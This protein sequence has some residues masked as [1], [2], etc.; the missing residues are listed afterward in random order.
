MISP[1]ARQKDSFPLLA[2]E[3]EAVLRIVKKYPAQLAQVISAQYLKIFGRIGIH[4]Y[5][6]KPLHTFIIT[7]SGL[8][9]KE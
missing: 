1:L 8:P 9:D 7:G 6:Q 4:V 2:K 3:H 5:F